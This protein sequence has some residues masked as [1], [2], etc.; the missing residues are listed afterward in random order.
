MA[1]PKSL[2]ERVTHIEDHTA[3]TAPAAEAA[4][5]LE[6]A[7][8]MHRLETETLRALSPETADSRVNLGLTV[9]ALN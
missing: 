8:P 9:E 7:R 6:S 4:R 5:A 2:V 1:R 3:R